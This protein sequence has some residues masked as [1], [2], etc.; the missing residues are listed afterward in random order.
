MN[1]AQA[2]R[3]WEITEDEVK[4][5]CKE[6]GIEADNIPD[7]TVPVYVPDRIYESNPHRY[8]I[9]LLDVISNTHMEIKGIDPTILETC[10]AQLKE[11]KLIVLKKGADPDSLDYHDYLIS[12][13]VANYNEWYNSL[14]K[15][16]MSFLEKIISF[17]KSLFNK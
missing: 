13:E 9:Y 17:F 1:T 4:S 12:A 2:S 11:K 7:D 16:S 3:A 15:D 6:M 5:I 14:V 10:V 8:Y